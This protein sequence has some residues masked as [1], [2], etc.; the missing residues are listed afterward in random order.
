[1]VKRLKNYFTPPRR[2]DKIVPQGTGRTADG[3]E[4]FYS[5]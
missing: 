3:K 5:L 2:Y 1:M 4:H